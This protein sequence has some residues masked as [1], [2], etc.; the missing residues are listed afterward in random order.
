MSRLYF[1]YS[2]HRF[3]N[4]NAPASIL[5][6]F[7]QFSQLKEYLTNEA[8]SFRIESFEYILGSISNSMLNTT[9]S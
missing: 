8:L 7:S 4:S 3:F 2:C 6:S 1:L 9:S 5:S